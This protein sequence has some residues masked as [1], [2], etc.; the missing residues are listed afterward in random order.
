ML[1]LIP[2]TSFNTDAPPLWQWV[3]SH[4]GLNV[5]AYGAHAAPGTWPNDTERGLVVPASQLSWHQVVLPKVHHTRLPAVLAGLLE[6]RLL[7]DPEQL[8]F[9]LEPG[10]QPGATAP[11]WVAVCQRAWLQQSLQTLEQLQYPVSRIVP[12][13]APQD[14]PQLNVYADTVGTGDHVCW[15]MSGPQGVVTVPWQSD[16]AQGTPQPLAA[17][18]QQLAPW[19]TPTDTHSVWPDNLTASADSASM[20]HAEHTCP[21]LRW[22]LEPAAM[23]WL[24]AA[25]RDWDLAQFDFKLSAPARRRQWVQ[26]QLR[27][28]WQEPA[29]RPMRWGLA[30]LVMVQLAGLNL[31]AWQERR[32]LRAQQHAV[33]H[34]LTQTFPHITLVLDAPR[35]MRRELD[36]LRQRQGDTTGQDLESLLQAIGHSQQAGAWRYDKLNF[37]PESSTLNGV[38]LPAAN[39]RAVQARLA[40]YGWHTELQGADMR[41][42][43]IGATP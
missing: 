2:P 7:D 21:T 36:R 24:Q 16:M 32:E 34:T 33:Q 12:A 6:E 41:L 39:A 27:Q 29:W 20:G 40:Q 18:L 23:D 26:R 25:R 38:Q 28:L 35:Q 4:D 13:V 30:S 17:L 43:P 1:L 22:R 37:A 3:Q 11:V 14:T 8:H 19:P 15:Q 9:A 10:A 42:S 31:S 5:S